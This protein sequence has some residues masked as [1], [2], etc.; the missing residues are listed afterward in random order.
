MK[1]GNDHAAHLFVVFEP[2]FLNWTTRAICYLWATHEPVG[3]VYKNP[4]SKNDATIVI[5]SCNER[6]SIWITSGVC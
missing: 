1:K 2:Y 6:C 3:S 4:N 5:E